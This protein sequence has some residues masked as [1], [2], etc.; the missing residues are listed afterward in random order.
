MKSLH[1]HDA[2]SHPERAQESLMYRI[3]LLFIAV[4]KSADETIKK[5]KATCNDPSTT[6]KNRKKKLVQ[7]KKK[8][9]KR[10][11]KSAKNKKPSS[12]NHIEEL[13]VEL[14]IHRNVAPRK[15]GI[16][17]LQTNQMPQAEI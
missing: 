10:S 9:T 8:Q 4:Q 14:R 13:D 1:C 17:N 5:R 15:G 3:I 7:Q 16:Q 11:K 6:G 2:H 12:R